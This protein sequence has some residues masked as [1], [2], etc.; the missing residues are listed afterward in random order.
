MADAQRAARNGDGSG[1]FLYSEDVV[2]MGASPPLTKRV[3]QTV[4]SLFATGLLVGGLAAL[5]LALFQ[6]MAAFFVMTRMLGIRVDL[7]TAQVH[8][9]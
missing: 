9:S 2:D 3:V 5:G 1:K 8:A 6:L 7:D 4:G